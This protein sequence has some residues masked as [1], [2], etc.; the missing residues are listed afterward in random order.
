MSLGHL[1][2]HDDREVTRLDRQI[3]GWLRDDVGYREIQRIDG[4]GSVVAA[5]FTAEIG[6]VS[7]F[8]SA[9]Q[10]CSWVGVTPRHEKSP[11]R[12]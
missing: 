3:H 11:T 4:I 10:L 5:V 6:D 1:I 2:D 7:R 8:K 12:R 9:K